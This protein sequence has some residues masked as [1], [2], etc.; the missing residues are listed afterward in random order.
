[1]R[2]FTMNALAVAALVMASGCAA[3]GRSATIVAQPSGVRSAE[4][5]LTPDGRVAGRVCRS[6]SI[7]HPDYYD[8]VIVV[9][10][11]GGAVLAKRLAR[12]QAFVARS[13]VP[14]CA[15]FVASIGDAGAR[16]ATAEVT[17]RIPRAS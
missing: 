1:M 2:S 5:H 8:V 10:D 14:N 4:A 15:G 6:L 9:R 13:D 3:I 17:V 16:A 11:T 7:T 12:A